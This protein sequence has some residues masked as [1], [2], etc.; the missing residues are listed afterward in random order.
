MKSL[1]ILALTLLL[2]L[3]FNQSYSQSFTFGAKVGVNYSK[4]PSSKSLVSS[5]I[6][7]AGVQAGVF[8][9]FG[10]QIFLQPELLF[11]SYSGSFNL[12]TSAGEV[13]E[14]VKFTTMDIPVLLGDKVISLSTL[15][16]R[17]MLGPDFAFNLKKPGLQIPNPGDY[18]YKNATVGGIV[19]VGID[20]AAL[21]IDARYNFGLTDINASL[22]QKINSF[23]LSVG[24]KFL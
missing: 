10:K 21:T 16:L 19:G 4:F 20:L 3:A 9:R 1:K 14:D 18:S 15:N 11:G 17:V 8:A 6:G 7:K 24:F 12:K 5:D 22:G 2:G 13:A 23:N